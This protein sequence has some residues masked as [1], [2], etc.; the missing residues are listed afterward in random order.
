MIKM[1]AGTQIC[2]RFERGILFSGGGKCQ[3]TKAREY[4]TKKFVAMS[5]YLA[6]LRWLGKKKAACLFLA[7]SHPDTGDATGSTDHFR[8][9]CHIVYNLNAGALPTRFSTRW[10]LGDKPCQTFGRRFLAVVWPQYFRTNSPNSERDIAKEVDRY[11]KNPGRG[12]AT[13]SGNSRS[14]HCGI[15]HN[16]RVCPSFDIRAFR[17]AVL[18]QGS[19][20]PDRLERRAGGCF[21]DTERSR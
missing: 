8:G 17:E 19:L 3:I 15:A 2:R 10:R 1:T 5:A 14:S 12:P 13:Q 21:S 11:I 7:A 6:R 20:L 4:R 18:G 16:A 9:V